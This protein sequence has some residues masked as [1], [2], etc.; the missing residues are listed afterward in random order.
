MTL[1]IKKYT[2]YLYICSVL[3]LQIALPQTALA[4]IE[5]YGTATVTDS[6]GNT[7]TPPP[8]DNFWSYKDITLGAVRGG[9]AIIVTDQ[10][11]LS[12][13][14]T[15]LFRVINLGGNGIQISGEQAYLSTNKLILPDIYGNISI[16]LGAQLYTHAGEINGTITLD[17]NA[18]WIST[19]DVFFDGTPA[20]VG[21]LPHLGAYNNSK[22]VINGEL[23]MLNTLLTI[24]NSTLNYPNEA[25]PSVVNLNYSGSDLK[26]EKAAHIV[27]GNSNI[28]HTTTNP[29]TT[30]DLKEASVWRNM[31]DFNI[32]DGA[33]NG[34]IIQARLVRSDLII[35]GDLNVNTK[36]D[37]ENKIE[38]TNSLLSAQN[39][40]LNSLI[41]VTSNTSNIKSNSINI[42]RAVMYIYRDSALTASNNIT[43]GE[44]NEG[45]II[46]SSD[47]ILNAGS[48]DIAKNSGSSGLLYISDTNISNK[49]GTINT[50]VI[51]IGSGDGLINFAH[52]INSADEYGIKR[53]ALAYQFTPN[54]IGDGQIVNSN[55]D[56]ALTGDYTGFSGQIINIT[57]TLFITPNATMN[58]NIDFITRNGVLNFDGGTQSV[59]N[60]E[61]EAHV[62]FGDG[63]ATIIT[64]NNYN[65]YNL[66][67]MAMESG[68]ANKP[69]LT[70]KLI[71][72]GNTSGTTYLRVRDVERAS[73]EVDD[74]IEIIEVLGNSNAEFILMG[75]YVLPDGQQAVAHGAY[76]YTLHK[77][78][79][80]ARAG[81]DKNWYM[82]RVGAPSNGG[83]SGNGGGNGGGG[84]EE[85]YQPAVSIYEAYP[86][87]LMEL[88][89]MPSLDEREGDRTYLAGMSG[90]VYIIL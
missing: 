74:G 75:D 33:G 89:R 54:L 84:G 38:L 44:N 65:A 32:G 23:T 16:A 3:A 18:S 30:I 56:T 12:A 46:I 78:A 58:N 42:D 27:T 45:T 72:T 34:N 40:N 60:I 7:F 80:T 70:D 13:T 24:S 36:P 68:F 25:N 79:N 11:Y 26:L 67:S 39:I 66:N 5:L 59:G 86:Q 10:S 4:A 17:R 31:G 43:I 82:R 64:A 22:T 28:A 52:T 77:G 6:S 88:G 8:S 50:P 41:N 62:N 2:K 83:N 14:D 71:V 29:Y 35:D 61:N 90:D 76:A 63:L 47:S 81:G 48:I 73:A 21:Y 20:P 1:N 53:S 9:S 19:S 57:G 87:A 55:G 15:F 37:N 85:I 69:G 51:R 49:I